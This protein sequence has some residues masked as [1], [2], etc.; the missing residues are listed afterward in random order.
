MISALTGELRRVEEDRVYVQAGPVLCEVLVPAADVD[1]LRLRTGETITFHTI[2]YLE[3]DAARGNLQPR[4]IGFLRPSDRRFFE[5]F[6]TVKGI[7]VRTALKALSE[8]AGAI[9]HA[10]ETRNTRFLMGLAGVGRRTA[11]LIVAALAGKVAEFA[12]E[13]AA[14]PAGPPAA[15]EQHEADA[16]EALVALGE[17]RPVAERLLERVR[18]AQ[19]GLRAADALIREMLRLRAG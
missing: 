4:L 10:I 19:P 15:Y 17:P 9:A 18:Q 11:E 14:A 6:T 13:A 12:V 16:I 3:G 8:P 1:D 7:G 2:M 5:I